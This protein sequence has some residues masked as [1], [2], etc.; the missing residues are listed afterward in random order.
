MTEHP[1]MYERILNGWNAGQTAPVIAQDLKCSLN[2]VK[3]AIITARDRGDPRAKRR[4]SVRQTTARG[5]KA[6]AKRR[7]ITRAALTNLLLATIVKDNLF[8]A[9]LD[10]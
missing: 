5:L 9:V 10:D 2:Y 7:G 6:E 8:G 4:N 1:T 3:S